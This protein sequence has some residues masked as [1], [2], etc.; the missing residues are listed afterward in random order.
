M[1]Q[2]IC[3]FLA[4]LFLLMAFTGCA[5][6][7]PEAVPETTA[8]ISLSGNLTEY[9]V[10]ERFTGSWSGLEDTYRVTADAEI[11]LPNSDRMVTA[12]V[13][14]RVFSQEEADAMM[15]VFLKGNTLYKEE[16]ATKEDY[17]E[18]LARYEAI[19]RGEIPYTGDHSIDTVP[20]MI[21][22]T[23]RDMEAAPKEGERFEADTSYH[24]PEYGHDATI[25]EDWGERVIEGY[26]EVDERIIHCS[27]RN[28]KEPTAQIPRVQ[29]NFWEEGYGN[30]NSTPNLSDE[31]F[32]NDVSDAPPVDPG[33]SEEQAQSLADALL[34]ELGMDTFTLDAVTPVTFGPY[35]GD[36]WYHK[37]VH[38]PDGE[39]GYRLMYVRNIGG[40]PLTW[41][42]E[43]GSA[44]EENVPDI[45]CWSDE[46]VQLLVKEDRVVWF[47]WESPY[48]EPEILEENAPL[49]PFSDIQDIFSKMIFVKN[50]YLQEANQINGYDTIHTVN[51]DKVQLTMMRTR[52]RNSVS[53]GTLIPVWDFW[54]ETSFHTESE[55]HKQYVHDGRYYNVVLT[56]NAI[57]GTIVDREIGY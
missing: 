24:M 33:F 37:S 4:A 21:A 32:W 12:S 11:I 14:P 34:M 39:T 48:T 3:I 41:T 16:T 8:E 2:L 36:T 55:E 1:K 51:V 46:K 47:S 30:Y 26:A 20:D 18:T 57:D 22:R 13:K 25:T 40:L 35:N 31:M 43:D 50:H 5:Q 44:F 10:P 15:A 27:F 23:K 52:P 29:A 45:G 56:I 19:L 53:E 38:N 7:S 6:A 17:A 28:Y 42:K 54:A 49:L 9:Q